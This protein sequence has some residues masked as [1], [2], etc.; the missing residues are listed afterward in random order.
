MST[1][2]I[3]Y[4]PVTCKYQVNYKLVNITKI[5]IIECAPDNLDKQQLFFGYFKLIVKQKIQL[6]YHFVYRFHFKDF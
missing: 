5:C 1:E 4:S 3:C 2:N 6:F